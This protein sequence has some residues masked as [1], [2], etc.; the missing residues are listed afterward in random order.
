MLDYGK[1]YEVDSFLT[2][3]E[4]KQTIIEFEQGKW[5]LHAGE[6]ELR[7]TH[8]IPIRTF[9]YKQLD[10]GGYIETILKK[11][12]ETILKCKI[13]TIR[14]YG[15]GQTHSQTA[16]VHTDDSTNDGNTYGSLVYYLHK[17]WQPHLGGHL[18][19]VEGNEVVKSI[20][21]KSNSAVIFNSIMNHCAL[22]PTVYCLDM[23]TSI[24]LKFK[25][26]NDN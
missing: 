7:N 6:L 10:H 5:D 13:E 8:R 23:R 15:N 12:I 21:P 9:W 26:I 24:A 3:D 11:K 14:I 20:F 18:I 2:E 22:E 1:I 17:N 25:V 19:F 16:W 4:L